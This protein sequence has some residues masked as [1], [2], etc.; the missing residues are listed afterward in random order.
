KPFVRHCHMRM[1]AAGIAPSRHSNS[2]QFAF[3]SSSSQFPVQL[4]YFPPATELHGSQPPANPAVHLLEE[5][6][7]SSIHEVIRPS[8]QI[9]IQRLLYQRFHI[10]RLVSACNLLRAFLELLLRLVRRVDV[11]LPELIPEEG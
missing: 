4:A 7:A 1:S 11:I 8:P 5:R 3:V 2:R 6:N 9:R 10:H